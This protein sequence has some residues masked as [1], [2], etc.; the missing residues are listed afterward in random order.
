M[1]VSCDIDLA[2]PLL[3]RT[4]HVAVSFTVYLNTSDQGFVLRPSCVPEK[5]DVNTKS[6]NQNVIPI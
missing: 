3:H 4:I 1:L 2:V 5:V 6:V